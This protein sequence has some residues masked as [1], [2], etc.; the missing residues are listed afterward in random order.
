M[1]VI[2][3]EYAKDEIFNIKYNKS[4]DKLEFSK[5]KTSYLLNCLSDNRFIKF[6]IF[7]TII[8]STI[9]IIFIYNFINLLASL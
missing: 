8:F 3:M 6:I 5:N 7:L 9:N 4:N 2:K 1:G